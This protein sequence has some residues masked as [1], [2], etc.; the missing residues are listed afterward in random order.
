MIITLISKFFG[1]REATSVDYA[2]CYQQFG[3]NFSTH[4]DVLNYLHRHADCKETY[5]VHLTSGRVDGA[6]CV[7]HNKILANDISANKLIDHPELPIAKD[8]LIL[9]ITN[10]RNLLIPFKSKIVSS[11]HSNIVNRCELFNARRT[12]CL[13]KSIDAFSKRTVKKRNRELKN[14]IDAGGSIRDQSEFT[15]HELIEI[16]ASLFEKRRG[17]QLVDRPHVT[18]FINAFRENIFGKILFY[19]ASPCAFQL[20]T[21]CLSQDIA[22]FDFINIGIDQTVT[23]Y[24]VGSLLMWININEA[25]RS[26]GAEKRHV[27][28]SYGRPTAEYKN[29]W[30]FQEK[31]GRLL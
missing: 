30:C 10:K 9:P 13:A 3:G 27:R 7:W 12:I 21:R 11:I 17:K 20:I 26:F 5:Y 15:A 29:Q 14:F 31:L 6:I 4:P 24:S 1:W 18:D 2:Q 8:E 25:Y 22:A 28:F 23:N 19:N 16:Y